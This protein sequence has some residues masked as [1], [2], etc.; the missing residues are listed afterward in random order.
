[1]Q[2]FQLV[3][4]N[5][6]FKKQI[7]TD[8]IGGAPLLHPQT[9][10]RTRLNVN[11]IWKSDKCIGLERGKTPVTVILSVC[12]FLLILICFQFVQ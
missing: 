11:Y 5:I 9:L 2:Q 7:T 1:M 8:N 12:A 4:I 10:R 3:Y 6:N